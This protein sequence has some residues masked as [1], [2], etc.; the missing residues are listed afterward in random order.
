MHWL[1]ISV[2]DRRHFSP[3]WG[4]VLSWPEA[5]VVHR[6]LLRQIVFLDQITSQDFILVK[7][8][9]NLASCMSGVWTDGSHLTTSTDHRRY[10]THQCE[11]FQT[12][13]RKLDVWHWSLFS[14]QKQRQLG[15]Q[16]CQ[17]SLEHPK[18]A[19]LLTPCWPH[20]A[21]LA[22]FG[23]Q[24]FLWKCERGFPLVPSCWWQDSWF[25]AGVL[26]RQDSGV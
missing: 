12:F 10:P 24:S 7:M 5:H 19:I 16:A 14:S 4:N 20:S 15:S 2:S 11:E 23:Q 21:L 9:T 18:C 8:N 17:Q 22:L 3:F 25:G 1:G 26:G 13:I 6:P